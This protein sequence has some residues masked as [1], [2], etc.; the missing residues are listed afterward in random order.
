MHAHEQKDDMTGQKYS[1]MGL[2]LQTFPGKQHNRMDQ[3]Y[4]DL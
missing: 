3:E 4:L 1:N 2:C